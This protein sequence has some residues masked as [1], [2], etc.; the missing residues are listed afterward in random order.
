MKKGKKKIAKQSGKHKEAVIRRGS[1]KKKRRQKLFLP[2]LFALISGDGL[3]RGREIVAVVFR[4]KFL[5]FVPVSSSSSFLHSP[6]KGG[7][8]GEAPLRN[9]G[10]EGD[11]DDDDTI[12]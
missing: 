2:S 9:K 3:D 5:Q 10:G 7:G 1:A 4:G 8:G 6:G 11:G 12:E